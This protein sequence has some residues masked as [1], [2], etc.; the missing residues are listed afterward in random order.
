MADRPGQGLPRAEGQRQ[1]DR[2]SD[3]PGA[4]QR[5]RPGGAAAA[6]PAL[7]QGGTPRRGGEVRPPGA[8]D[9]RA[10]RA[11]AADIDRGAASAEQEG[12]GGGVRQVDSTVA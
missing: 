10:G 3:R 11:V 7:A 9:R 2:R 5:R 4:D 8:G 1:A 6:R 12:G